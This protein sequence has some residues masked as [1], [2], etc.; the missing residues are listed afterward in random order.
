MKNRKPWKNWGLSLVSL[1]MLLACA[2]KSFGEPKD[3]TVTWSDNSDNE[4]EFVL[5]QFDTTLAAP[6]WVVVATLAANTELAVVQFDAT[7]GD[8]VALTARNPAGESG[9][10]VHTIDPIYIR[11]PAMPGF[12]DFTPNS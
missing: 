11:I 4:S 3:W 6:D 8:R 9:M 1:L 5:Y 12:M 7:K 10:A 2:E